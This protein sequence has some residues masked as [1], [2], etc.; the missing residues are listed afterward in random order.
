MARRA[1]PKRTP[2]EFLLDELGDVTVKQ[3]RFFGCTALYRGPE[4]L[5]ILRQAEKHPEDNGV[6]VACPRAQHEALRRELPSLRF[7][8]VLGGASSE[9]MLIPEDVPTFES[10]VRRAGE[11]VRASDPRIGKVPK[12]RRPRRASH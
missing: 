3:R 12:A 6:W 1:A 7:V 4:I 8:G 5:F 10:E 11:L 9:W 2:F